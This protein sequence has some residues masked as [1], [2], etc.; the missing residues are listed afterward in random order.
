MAAAA[1]AAAAASAAGSPATGSPTDGSSSRA[2][3][4][5]EA[6]FC[7]ALYQWQCA[8]CTTTSPTLPQTPTMLAF[9]GAVR[10]RLVAQ[11]ALNAARH[12]HIA[13]AADWEAA[14]A[15][16]AAGLAPP[17]GAPP[18]EPAR[19]AEL[20]A[21]LPAVPPPPPLAP[22]AAAR[23]RCP[24]CGAPPLRASAAA[25]DGDAAA[26]A[27][28]NL[29]LLV[30]TLAAGDDGDADEEEGAA[31]GA[32]EEG[33]RGDAAACAAAGA[34]AAADADAAAAAADAAAHEAAFAA[35][36]ARQRT[37]AYLAAHG[38]SLAAVRAALAAPAGAGGGGA[39]SGG[40][41]GAPRTALADAEGA[42]F[43]PAGGGFAPVVALAYDARMLLH[44]EPARPASRGGGGGGLA[45]ALPGV[46]LPRAPA[47]A[48]PER[49]DRLRAIAAHLVARGLL[50]RC[51]RVPA[52][53]AARAELA[54]VHGAGFLDAVDALPE[55]VAAGGGAFL[56]DGGDTFANAATLA[57]AR[58][59]AGSVV[60]VAQAVARGAADRGLALV[61]PPGHHAEPDCAMGFCV[62]NNVAVAAA[63]AIATGAARRVLIVDWDVHHGNG[64]ARAAKRCA[65]PRRAVR[66]PTSPP[67]LPARLHP[68]RRHGEHVLRGPARA[69]RVDSPL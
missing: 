15:A 65:Q 31:G 2:S 30:A 21:A 10:A 39:D 22:R 69:V 44:E 36:G 25:R 47:T 53:D 46:A 43:L 49:P 12:A 5:D 29:D 50:Q 1:A 26:A 68:R 32:A 42:V 54:R 13:A 8:N 64:T 66:S 45:A 38:L 61:R 7:A 6:R 59:A 23:Q 17:P 51:V 40:G 60:A 3:S 34:D 19:I 56:F 52:R 4:S 28:V 48:H 14:A 20:A 62:Y 67:P 33:A 37:Q 9:A 24:E 57:A 11:R 16:A 35:V 41:G 63:D 18:A 55:R 58:L 27:D